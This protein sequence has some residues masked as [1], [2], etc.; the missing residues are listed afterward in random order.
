MWDDGVAPETAIDFDAPH[1]P[2][3]KALGMW[4][5]GFTFFATI[6]GLV[7]LYDPATLSVNEIVR[8]SASAVIV[9]YLSVTPLGWL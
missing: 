7:S 4:L 5:G 8:G 6:G 2:K 1:V 9:L 3:M